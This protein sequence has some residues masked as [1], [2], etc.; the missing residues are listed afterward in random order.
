MLISKEIGAMNGEV[1]LM[2]EPTGGRGEPPSQMSGCCFL[3]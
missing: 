3:G 2:T 1:S